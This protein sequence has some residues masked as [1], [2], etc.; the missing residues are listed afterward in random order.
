[1]LVQSARN[2]N[3]CGSNVSQF[4]TLHYITEHTKIDNAA[5]KPKAQCTQL[6]NVAYKA[7]AQHTTPKHRTSALMC[8]GHRH[9]LFIPAGITSPICAIPSR[10]A[11]VV[12]VIPMF[13]FVSAIH[14]GLSLDTFI[15]C[16]GPNKHIHTGSIK[17]G[18]W[19]VEVVNTFWLVPARKTCLFYAML[20]RRAQ[21]II[22]IFSIVPVIHRGLS[23]STF[24][25]CCGLNQHIHRDLGLGESRPA[26]RS[27]MGWGELRPV[28]RSGLGLGE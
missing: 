23:L 27:G 2:A 6:V 16:C 14:G 17:P 21:A 4:Q 19:R 25:R 9:G 7:T 12:A 11:Q 3:C 1:M 8:R 28:A 26:A 18:L 20:T 22:A 10:R 15:R 24:I 5:H 13:S